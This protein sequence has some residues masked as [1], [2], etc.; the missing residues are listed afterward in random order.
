MILRT[1]GLEYPERKY[2]YCYAGKM[3]MPKVYIKVKKLRKKNGYTPSNEVILDLCYGLLNETKRDDN[4][5]LRD[6][7]DDF[8]RKMRLTGLFSLRGGG[9]F[10]D[11]NTKESTDCRLYSEKLHFL[12][13]I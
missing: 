2:L 10:V 8:I 1:K 13:R 6:Y 11:I 7:P 4:S 9:R 3:T 5:I 12:Q